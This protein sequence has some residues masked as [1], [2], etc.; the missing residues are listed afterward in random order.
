MSADGMNGE[1]QKADP[2]SIIQSD[3][4]VNTVDW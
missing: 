4:P 1:A 3:L 2:K